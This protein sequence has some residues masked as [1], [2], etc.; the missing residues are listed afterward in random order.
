MPREIALHGLYMPTLTLL[1]VVAAVLCWCLDRLL[2]GANL[3]RL[4]WH[5]ALFRVCLF[6]CLFAGMA[7]PLYR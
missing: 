6:A 2:A 3:Y 7:L 1:F 4:V 5:P